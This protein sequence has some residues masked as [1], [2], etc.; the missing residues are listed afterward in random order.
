MKLFKL[1][2]EKKKYNDASRAICMGHHASFVKESSDAQA[3]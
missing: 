2:Y 1:L 3:N